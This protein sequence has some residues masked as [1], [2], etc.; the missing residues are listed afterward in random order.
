L[1][2]AKNVDYLSRLPK[3]NG[4]DGFADF[5]RGLKPGQRSPIVETKDFGSNPGA[6]RMFTFAPDNLQPHPALSSCCTAVVK[7]LPVTIWAPAGRPWRSITVSR[8]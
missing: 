6:L 1:S 8:S 7:V 2:L 5:G 4:I 3:L